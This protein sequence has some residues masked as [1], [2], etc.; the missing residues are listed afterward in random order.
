MD[1]KRCEQMK[2]IRP[3]TPL[4]MDL[5]A[6]SQNKIYSSDVLPIDSHTLTSKVTL[7]YDS[8]HEMLQ[9]IAIQKG[10]KIYDPECYAAFL[11]EILDEPDLA[12][13]FDDL[14]KEKDR[15]EHHGISITEEECELLIE[16]IKTLRN[17]IASSHLN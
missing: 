11:K 12:E 1:W 7:A 3:D 5:L 15:L 6:S 9:A 4:M 16:K 10:W 13:L 14:R 8:L 17:L 2:N